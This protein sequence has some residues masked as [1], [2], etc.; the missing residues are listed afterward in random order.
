MTKII[1]YLVLQLFPNTVAISLKSCISISYID[2]R[3]G[4]DTSDF[5][6]IIQPFIQINKKAS[7]LAVILNKEKKNGRKHM[8][9]SHQPPKSRRLRKFFSIL[10]NGKDGI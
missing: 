1:G 10:V 2:E 7:H 5:F 9:S 6:K 4:M 3:I 8:V